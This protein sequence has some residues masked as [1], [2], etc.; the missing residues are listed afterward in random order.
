MSQ[1]QLWYEKLHSSFGQYFSIKEVLYRDKTD[2]QDLIIFDTEEFGRVM[3]LNHVVQTTERDEFIYHEMMTHVPLLAHGDAKKVLIIGE[4]TGGFYVKCAA[5]PVL[6]KLSWSK[7][8][9]MWSI[10]AKN[11]F[12]TIM[13]GLMMIRDFS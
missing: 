2:H 11:I 8:I 5:M 13:Q 1:K 9:K 6:K 12:L 7:L 10:Y 3:A 4:E